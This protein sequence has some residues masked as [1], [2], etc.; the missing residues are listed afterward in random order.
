MRLRGSVLN[1]WG[2]RGLPRGCLCPSG[3]SR[4]V[5]SRSAMAWLRRVAVRI[6]G[7]DVTP[8]PVIS[9]VGPMCNSVPIDLSVAP[10]Y[11]SLYGTGFALAAPSLSTCSIAGQTLSVTYAGPQTETAGFDPLTL[12][13]AKRSGGGET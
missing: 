2:R 13:V 11:L 4:P 1:A 5:C 6:S 3:R 12:L 10:V 9:C 7:H 8:V